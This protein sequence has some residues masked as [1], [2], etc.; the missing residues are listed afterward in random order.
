MQ[1]DFAKKKKQIYPILLTFLNY[2]VM[3]TIIIVYRLQ[4]L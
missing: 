2:D 3:E 1:Q 4:V